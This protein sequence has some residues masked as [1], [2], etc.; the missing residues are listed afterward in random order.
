MH[1]AVLLSGALLLASPDAH[2]TTVKLMSLLEKTETSPLVVHGIIERV[3]A[4]W[5][6]FGARVETIVTLS[7]VESIKGH[8]PAGE[9]VTFRQGGGTIDGFTQ[10]APGLSVFEEGEEVIMFLEPYLETY[11]PIGIGIGEYEV[12]TE[13]SGKYVFHDPKV[14]AVRFSSDQPMRIEPHQP[15]TPEPLDRFLERIRGYARGDR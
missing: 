8:V 14:A 13:P 12:K 11:V 9:R 2:A 5:A 1:R 3:E 15:M 7:V 4:R 10:T 6:V